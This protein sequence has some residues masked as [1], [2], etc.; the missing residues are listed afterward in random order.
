[1]I[2]KVS[3][4]INQN[5]ATIF[6][7]SRPGKVGYHLPALDVEAEPLDSL[8]DANLRRDDD[9]AQ[10]PEVSE[11]D[12]IRHFTRISTWNYA[13]DFGMYPLGSC[14]MKYNPKINERVSR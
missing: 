10:L 4:H 5:E 1:M 9:P 7:R 2:K 11:V 8:L 12:V 13:V 6:E 14:T 3:T